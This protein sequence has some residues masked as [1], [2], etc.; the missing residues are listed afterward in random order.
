MSTVGSVLGNV[1]A[2][3]VSANPISAIVGLG[4]DLIDKF[5]PDPAAK[6]AAQ[7]HVLDVQAQMQ[8][9]VIDQQNKIIEASSANVKDDHYMQWMR[10]FFCFSMTIMYIWNYAGCRFA[11]QQPVDIPTSMHAMFASIMLGFVGIPAGIEMAK[12]VAAM[13]GESSASVLG[14]VIKAGNK[15]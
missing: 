3:A 7:A 2:G 10:A 12:Q 14:G 4:K 5:V 1:A 8:A 6:A 9:E 11:G 15:S 13:P